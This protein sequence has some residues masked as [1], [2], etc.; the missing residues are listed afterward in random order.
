MTPPS[1]RPWLKSYSEGVP[2]DIKVDQYTSLVQLMEDSFRQYADRPAYSFMGKS[3]SYAQIDSVSTAFATYLQ[4]LGLV[5]GDRVA[6]MMPN[7]PQYPVAV[8]AILRAGWWWSMS[9]R[10]TPRANW[11]TS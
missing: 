7:V 6:V 4:G 11:S 5:K 9:T 2:A 3:F 10:C 8:A 1:P